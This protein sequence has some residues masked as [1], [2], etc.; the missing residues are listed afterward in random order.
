M[1]TLRPPLAGCCQRGTAGRSPV[2]EPATGLSEGPGGPARRG[3]KHR[4][5]HSKCPENAEEEKARHRCRASMQLDGDELRHP[6]LLHRHAIEPVRDLHRFTV[7][8]DQDELCVMLHPAQHLD[9]PPDIGVV[10]GGI[11]LVQ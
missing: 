3:T 4:L 6:G 11:D 7:V 2:T 1:G 10:E 8:R 9:E 5:R